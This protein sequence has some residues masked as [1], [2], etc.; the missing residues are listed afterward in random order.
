MSNPVNSSSQSKTNI[1][2]VI[3]IIV[4]VAAVA[5]L[6]GKMQS[7]SSTSNTLNKVTV[8]DK[9]QDQ[10][11]QDNQLDA[12]S[13]SEEPA[14][15][16]GGQNDSGNNSNGDA[17]NPK[18]DDTSDD[19]GGGNMPTGFGLVGTK[20]KV[21]GEE[22]AENSECV[23]GFCMKEDSLGKFGVNA[24]DK[25]A[26]GICK[27]KPKT[28]PEVDQPIC[29]CDNIRYKNSCLAFKSGINVS[30]RVSCQ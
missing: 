27:A 12:N 30:Q 8:K 28:C 3:I 18:D 5:F 22:C 21:V 11:E 10:P 24:C 19:G 20:L 29:G 17:N 13:V 4:L 1:F 6:Y 15:D 16:S 7:D 9:A 2:L 23:T 26:T 14:Q 25:G